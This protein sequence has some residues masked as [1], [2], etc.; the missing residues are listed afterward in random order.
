MKNEF[1]NLSSLQRARQRNTAVMLCI[2][3]SLLFMP[4]GC[5]SK[6][7]IMNVDDDENQTPMTDENPLTE[8]ELY[9]G[10]D[11]Y[12]GDGG[13]EEYFKIRKDKIVIKTKSVEEAKALCK[14][15]IFLRAYDVNGIWVLAT[16]DPRQINLEDLLQMENIIGATYAFEYADGTL[17]YPKDKIYIKFIDEK[18]PDEV[19]AA[20]GLTENVVAIELFNE[21]STGYLVT[22]DVN[23]GDILQLSRTLF[24]SGLCKSASPSFILEIKSHI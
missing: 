17:Q 5:G 4:A 10:S 16:I 22:F 1:K 23:L 20:I 13:K 3:C 7:N 2:V 6:S 18:S 11:F 12:Y 9:D 19:F 24:E 8:D 15:D 21:Y 14:Q